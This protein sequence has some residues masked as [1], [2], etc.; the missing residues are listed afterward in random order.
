MQLDEAQKQKVSSWIA[1]GRS[2]S[3]IQKLLESELKLRV[4]YLEV[5]L[6][7]DDLKLMPK[8][9]PRAEEKKLPAPAVDKADSPM[10]LSPD[11]VPEPAAPPV[12]GTVSVS[13]DTLARPG[14]VVSGTVRFSDGKTAKWVLDQTGRLGLMPEVQG[15]RP[16]PEDVQE[17]QIQL[18][19]V[20][21]GMGM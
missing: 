17:F 21:Q 11:P 6:L 15:Y 20:L 3:E 13:V 9:T 18:Q 10:K 12:G 14:A 7:V 16:S 2:L 19:N 8:D 4:T 1:E 5:R